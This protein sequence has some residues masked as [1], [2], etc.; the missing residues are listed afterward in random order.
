V[1]LWNLQTFAI[2]EKTWMCSL[3]DDLKHTT[4]CQRNSLK[5]NI[6]YRGQKSIPVGGYFIPEEYNSFTCL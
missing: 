2:S 1:S 6:H 5:S 3:Q 4:C